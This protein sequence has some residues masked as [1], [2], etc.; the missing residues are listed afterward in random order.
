MLG[1]FTRTS[2]KIVSLCLIAL[3]LSL[4]CAPKRQAELDFT[5]L[6]QCPD[7]LVA[8][9]VGLC[10]KGFFSADES[11]QFFGT[12]MVKR[13]YL[14]VQISLSNA[15]AESCSLTPASFRLT[16]HET[17][18]VPSPARAVYKDIRASLGGNTAV[19]SVAF[20]VVVGFAGFFATKHHNDKM[21]AKLQR[22]SFQDVTLQPGQSLQTVL[23]FPLPDE[24]AIYN[25]KYPTGAVLHFLKGE[26]G[27]SVLDF[28]L[29][30]PI[31][32]RP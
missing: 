17:E 19:L 22:N 27:A 25:K 2:C 12:N 4:S 3:F 11:K 30:E 26:E 1:I 14:P 13:G 24:P 15:G 7:Q 20:G 28:D 10:A 21:A 8:N 6:S 31:P 5:S 16:Y 23:Y 18:C 29:H 9:G 32:E